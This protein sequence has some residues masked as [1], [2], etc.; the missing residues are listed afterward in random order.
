MN[1]VIELD[2]STSALVTP[3]M[4]PGPLSMAMQ[5]IKAGMGI[6]DMLAMLD[7]QKDWEANEARK[8][9]ALAM[10]AFKA[11]PVGI[12]KTKAVGYIA[13][14]GSLVTYNH[15]ELSDVTTAISPAMSRHQL[16][17]RW[18]VIQENGLITVKC[19]ITHSM[20]HSESISMTAFPDN[21]GDKNAIQQIA[22]TVSYLERYTL[23]AI[24]GMS[25]KGT[26]D[27]AQGG[28]YP[29]QDLANVKTA[30]ADAVSHAAPA[31][32]PQ[33]KFDTNLPAWTTLIQSGKKTAEA[34]IKNVSLV[35]VMSETQKATIL[36]IAARSA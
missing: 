27:D 7:L 32:Y 4:V 29:R 13:N 17:H 35:A 3:A 5:A 10:S 26:D 11:E 36:A 8:A 14:D 23:L 9:Y 30:Q 6:A 22:S 33:A 31:T 18:D 25:A 16:S 15:A 12:F 19:L 2:L 28:A 24:T 21:S 20:G 34:I 1:N